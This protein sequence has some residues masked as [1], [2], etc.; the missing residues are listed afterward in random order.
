VT[1]ETE[2]VNPH[3]VRT[4]EEWREQL[5]PQQYEILRR[6]GT[7]PPFTGEYVFS[8][9][10]GTY[11]CAACGHQ[12]FSSGAKFESGTGWP[13]FTAPAI[14]EN[15]ELRSDDS[16]GMVRTEVRCGN[17]DSHLGHVFDDGPGPG[18]QRY[19]INSAALDLQPVDE[20][21]S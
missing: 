11:R 9:A 3:C 4:E 17:C 2:A 15:V 20:A 19:C 1:P 14:A 7:E 12:L 21:R 10:D 16:H 8:K 18:G 5:T 13:S 6:D